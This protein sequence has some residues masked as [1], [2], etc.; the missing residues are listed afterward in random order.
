MSASALRDVPRFITLIMTHKPTIPIVATTKSR[1]MRMPGGMHSSHPR[2]ASMRV[3]H[4][5]W[6]KS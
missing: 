6:A 3:W 4:L 2:N 1:A 5:Q